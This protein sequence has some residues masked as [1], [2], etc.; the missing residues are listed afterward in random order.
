MSDPGGRPCPSVP[1]SWC[2]PPPGAGRVGASPDLERPV[3][4]IDLVHVTH[5]GFC[6]S[7]PFQGE[8]KTEGGLVN[9]VQETS[10]IP[11]LGAVHRGS[12]G[13]VLIVASQESRQPGNGG[14]VGSWLADRPEEWGVTVL[15]LSQASQ[16]RHKSR[17]SL[18]RSVA[19]L[20][21]V[22]SSHQLSDGGVEKDLTGPV[23]RERI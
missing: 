22:A 15:P 14:V 17:F 6:R 16:Q 4:E 19:L 13:C 20:V 9:F 8:A 11:L 1:S 2:R 7:P 21:F 18:D 10:V 23:R 3:G 12:R 5:V